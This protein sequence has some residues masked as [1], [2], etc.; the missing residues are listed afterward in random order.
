MGLPATSIAGSTCFRRVGSGFTVFARNR[1]KHATQ[2]DFSFGNRTFPVQSKAPLFLFLFFFLV[3]LLLF[4]R[5][6]RR[7]LQL[8]LDGLGFRRRHA[9][10]RLEWHFLVLGVVEDQVER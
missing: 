6:R 7:V 4:W 5:R 2:V 9:L 8:A 10:L 3:F 1:R